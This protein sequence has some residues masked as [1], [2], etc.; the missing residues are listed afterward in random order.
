MRL[1]GTPLLRGSLHCLRAI[2]HVPWVETFGPGVPSGSIFRSRL[3][4]RVHCGS[5]RAIPGRVHFRSE[6]VCV[7]GPIVRR[8]LGRVRFGSERVSRSGHRVQVGSLSRQPGPCAF[9]SCVRFGSE[10]VCVLGQTCAQPG[11]AV[12]IL[13]PHA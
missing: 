6:A 12:C 11:W 2:Q 3:H 5:Y 13:G 10:A 1:F 9:G 8:S 4:G 7:L